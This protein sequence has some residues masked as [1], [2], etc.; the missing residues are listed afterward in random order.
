M[1]RES[2]GY[3]CNSHEVSNYINYQNDFVNPQEVPICMSMCL[4]TIAR[5]GPSFAHFF[6]LILKF[7]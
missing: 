5:F 6:S 7:C 3:F 2:D 1:S 4:N